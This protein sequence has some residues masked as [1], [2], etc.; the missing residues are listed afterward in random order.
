MDK[1]GERR[2]PKSI[3]AQWCKSKGPKPIPHFETSAKENTKVEA[4]FL[5]AAQMAVNNR[6]APDSKEV[7]IP[8]FIVLSKQ[9]QQQQ[10]KSSS[11]C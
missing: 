6:D 8:D 5:E 7:A 1:E 2:V 11:C 10:Q 4:A 3:A 9:N